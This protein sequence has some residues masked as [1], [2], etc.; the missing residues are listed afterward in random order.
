VPADFGGLLAKAKGPAAP[1]M[2]MEEPEVEADPKRERVLPIAD[3][4]IAAVKAGERE[5]VADALIAAV[6][7]CY[8]GGDEEM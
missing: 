3:D 7:A 6:E 4:L 1:M 2:P 8:G 5:G